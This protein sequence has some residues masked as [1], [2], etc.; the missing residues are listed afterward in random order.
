MALRDLAKAGG[1]AAGIVAGVDRLDVEGEEASQGARVVDHRRAGQIEE[2]RTV[3]DGVAREED[4]RP[5]LPE[6]DA[7]GG[8]SGQVEHLEGPIPEIDHVPVPDRRREGRA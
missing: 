7:A 6:P 3:V 4:A 5:L 1:P 2:K 8:V